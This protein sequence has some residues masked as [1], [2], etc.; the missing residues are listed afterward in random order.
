M[1]EQLLSLPRE[2]GAH[3]ETGQPIVASIGRYG[4]YLMHD[5][6]YARLTS[7]AEV[8]DTGMNAAV[9]KLA[10]A[11]AAKGQ[12]AAEGASRSRCS[13]RIRNG[14]GDQ[15]DGGRYGPYV[16]DGTTHATLPKSADPK[17]VTL[18]EAVALIAE[19]AAKGPSKGKRKAPAKRKALGRSSPAGLDSQGP[20]RCGSCASRG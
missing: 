4:P 15:G 9:V 1:A 13:A 5:G 2:I 18:D 12:A 6:K 11:A 17:A 8:F 16:S 20:P 10:E 14:Q 7:T 3:P 19:K